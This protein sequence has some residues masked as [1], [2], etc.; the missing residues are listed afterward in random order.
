MNRGKGAYWRKL[1]NA[2]KL[3]SAASNKKDTR[4]FRVYCE[5]EEVVSEE[6]LQEALDRTT[7]KYPIFLSVMRKGLF[8]HY[9][10]KSSLRPVVKEEYREPCSNLYIRDKRELLFEVTYYNKRI[11][12]EVFHALTD[13]TGAV[14][15]MKELVKNYLILSHKEL[16]TWKEERPHISVSAMEDDGF[17][18]YYSKDVKRKDKKKQK[19]Y[20]I[21]NKKNKLN[22]LQITELEV[23]TKEVSARAKEY[24]VSM[25]VYLTSVFM[26]AIHR[27]MPRRQEDRPVILMIPVNLRKFF[28][29]DSMLNFFNW[30]EPDYH[31]GK[32]SD[33]LTDIISHVKGIF[34]RELTKQK[35]AERMNEYISLEVNPVLRFAPLE[36]KNL[37]ISAGTKT[38]A[39]E[40][41]AI[42]S[43][44]GIIRMPEEMEGYIHRFG[45]FTSTPKL[46]LCM[47]SFRDKIHLG[48]TSRYDSYDIKSAFCDIL[49]E[50]G[51]ETELLQPEYSEEVAADSKGMRLFK[52]FSFL[53]I[54]IAVLAVCIDYSWNQQLHLSFVIAGIAASTWLLSAMAFYKRHNLLKSAMWQLVIMTNVCALW[55]ILTGWRG[56]SVTFIYPLM[57]VFALIVMLGVVK[58][59]KREAAEYMIYVLMAAMYGLILPLVFIK[60]GL[61]HK[62]IPSMV[63]VAMSIIILA[64]LAIFRGKEMQ[65]ELEKKFHYK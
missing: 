24:G 18:K 53:E 64:A 39:R 35:M 32:G 19:A 37:C 47:C 54:V 12:F 27:A 59:Y 14:E 15:F 8:W 28:P 20:Q 5:L 55:D 29:S 1:D 26:A 63:S 46:E 16:R 25:T 6:V 23:N 13:G 60:V 33:S 7:E 56:W 43:N 4:V 36:L 61:V 11:N 41:T 57:S 22:N 30:I 42:F 10:E 50:E 48:F 62:V 44:M 49:K 45:I 58:I 38:S 2:A 21:N 9:L 3:Y 31:F 34:E 65:D 52:A 40:V 51:I 17:S